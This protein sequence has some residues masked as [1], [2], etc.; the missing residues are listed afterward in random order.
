MSRLTFPLLVCAL[1]AI[2]S[3]A[4]AQSIWHRR[5]PEF[6]HFFVDSRA[7]A[8]G[9]QLTVFIS[10][11]SEKAAREQRQ[12]GK[13]SDASFNFNFAGASSG[14]AGSS[15]S[16]NMA[17]D[18]ARAFDGNSQ[19]RSAQEYSD[20]VAVRVVDVL[21]NGYLLVRGRRRIMVA[22]EQREL[23]MSGIVR[24]MDVE[25]NNTVRSQFVADLDIQYVSC[26]SDSHFTNQ[27]WAARL[28]NRVWPF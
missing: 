12:N 23:R 22:D 25:P 9:D 17:G 28:I 11:N 18:S 8:I 16:V 4:S 15:A 26:G 2:C 19:L 3:P 24:P 13:S 14:G 27:G 7:H 20:R 1:L 5:S 10:V 6:A 21:P